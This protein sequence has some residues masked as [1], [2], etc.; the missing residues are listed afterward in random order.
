MHRFRHDLSGLLIR[1]S[2]RAPSAYRREA[3]CV[4]CMLSFFLSPRDPK[5]VCPNGRCIAERPA[6]EILAFSTGTM[7]HET[8]RVVTLIQFFAE[9]TAIR[10]S[11]IVA[12]LWFV[13]LVWPNQTT[14][15]YL[16]PKADSVPSRGVRR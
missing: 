12:S 2:P 14:G 15:D 16:L 1:D 9:E 7:R 13:G 4:S 6:G 8:V 10:F 3:F 11:Q 5:P